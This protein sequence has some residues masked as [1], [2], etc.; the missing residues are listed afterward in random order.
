MNDQS[1]SSGHQW[2]HRLMELIDI[3]TWDWWKSQVYVLREGKS[4]AE[5]EALF[6]EF[7]L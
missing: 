7:K 3:E 4:Y 2:D 6:F 1:R 5:A